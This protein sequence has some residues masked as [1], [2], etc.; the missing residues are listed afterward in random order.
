MPSF[1]AVADE[2]DSGRPAYPGGV[3]DALDP[4]AG[5][6]ALEGGAGTGIAAR[7][8]VDRG[9]RV[10]AFDVGARLLRRAV[11]HTPD[12]RAVIAD[13]ARLPFRDG[14]ADLICFAQSWHWVD[15]T[16][17]VPNRRAS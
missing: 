5:A 13:G 17:R 1:D 8:L 12:L 3:Y 15:P 4:I 9:A 16:R 6:L 2:Y 7:D 14:C 10:V 11:G